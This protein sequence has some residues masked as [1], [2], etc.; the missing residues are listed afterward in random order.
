MRN[1]IIGSSNLLIET[2]DKENRH[3]R[4]RYCHKLTAIVTVMLLL[5]SGC[6]QKT[7]DTA[8]KKESDSITDS[9]DVSETETHGKET[10]ETQITEETPDTQLTEE[11][12]ETLQEENTP[13]DRHEEDL[14]IQRSE[15]MEQKSS[16]DWSRI[17]DLPSEQEIAEFNE[18][19]ADR[20][21]Y[22]SGWLNIDPEMK[23]S[24]YS[25]DFK[26]DHL[27]YG[28]YF[29]CANIKMDLSSLEQ[30]YEEVSKDLWLSFYGGLQMREPETEGNSLMSFWDIYCKDK[31][32]ET[33][34]VHAKLIYPE[35]ETENVFD[36]EGSGVNFHNEYDWQIGRWYRMLFQCGRSEENGHT[37]VEQRICDLETGEWTKLCCYDTGLTD[38]CFVG[39]VALFLENYLPEYAGDIR[40]IEFKNIRIRPSNSTEWMAIKQIDLSANDWPGS[41]CFGSDDEHF[42]M[43]T[44]GIEGRS[45]QQCENPTTYTVTLG[46]DGSPYEE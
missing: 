44:T 36:N 35:N 37:T 40:T 11:V 38:S 25:I 28:T 20:A 19:S 17:M 33:S 13:K 34:V 41:F 1:K 43:I 29:G 9:A 16:R 21:P 7:V 30:E 24:E 46:L 31:T 22:V 26:A 12:P 5:I 18:K 10:V 4:K 45:L 42:W 14:P 39:N 32:G 6:A 15:P 27:P 8:T 23:F 3:K 2:E